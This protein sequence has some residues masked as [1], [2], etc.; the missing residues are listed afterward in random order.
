MFAR[1]KKRHE[2][3]G[4]G[5]KIIYPRGWAGELEG[6]VLDHAKKAGALVPSM[7]AATDKKAT[8]KDNAAAKK[9]KAIEDAEKA[10]DAAKVKLAAANTEAEKQAATS[11][12]AKA[13]TALA[14]AKA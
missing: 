1:F 11:D 13:E 9:A 12:V 8:V 2:Y 6:D 3:P 7:E 5:G 10:L 14:S 4:P